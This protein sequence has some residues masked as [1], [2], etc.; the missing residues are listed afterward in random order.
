MK[1]ENNNTS[2]KNFKQAMELKGVSNH[3]EE[4]NTSTE[5]F[6]ETRAKMM[7]KFISKGH[8][9]S[10]RLHSMSYMG[11]VSQH[12]ILTYNIWII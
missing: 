10:V 5:N 11:K 3:K 8:S 12:F 1:E 7:G 2:T 6:K 9:K 4:K